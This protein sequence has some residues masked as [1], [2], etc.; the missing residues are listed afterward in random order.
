MNR[1]HRNT[2]PVIFASFA[3]HRITILYSVAWRKPS[4]EIVP[5]MDALDGVDRSSAE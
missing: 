2:P 4:P 1:S 5:A 3:D